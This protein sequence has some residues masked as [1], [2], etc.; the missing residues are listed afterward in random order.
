[1]YDAIVIGAGQGGLAA[2]YYLKRNKLDYLILEASDQTAGSWPKYY[3][4]LTLFSP[5]RYSSLPGLAIPGHPDS[6]PLKEEVIRYLNKYRTHFNLHVKTNKKVI[7]VSKNSRSFTVTIQDGTTYQAK[8][9]INATGAFNHPYIPHI[10]GEEFFE[11]RVLHTY[12]YKRPESFEGE[13]V[14]VVGG[15]NSAVQVAVELAR[16]AEVSLATRTPIKYLPQKFLGKDG[17][18]WGRVIGVDTFPI[19]LWK[20]VRDKEPVI[21]LGGF[22]QSI[23]VDRNPDQRT[24]FK[25]FTKNGVEWTDGNIERI[26]SVIFATGFK[27]TFP[28]LESLPEAVGEDG[29]ALQRGGISTTIEGLYYVGLHWQRNHAS[30]T[31]RGVGPDAKF[32]LKRLKK[33]LRSIQNN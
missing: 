33:Y 25:K 5:I 23:E 20:T 18:F 2:G 4:S 1:M 28:Y 32:I 14:L 21:D 29:F 15:R 16:V 6:Y 8:A 17:H 22:K 3:D 7:G 31:L 30:A 9:I 10:E 19:G 24:M 26:D 11:G 12:Q 27:P 13:R